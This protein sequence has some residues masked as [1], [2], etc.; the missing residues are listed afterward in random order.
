MAAPAIGQDTL[1]WLESGTDLELRRVSAGVWHPVGGQIHATDPVTRFQ[2][3]PEVPTLSVPDAPAQVVGLRTDLA[4]GSAVMDNLMAFLALIWSD[5]PVTCGEHLWT[6][7]VDTGLASFMTP[8]NVVDLYDYEDFY[9]ELYISVTP[10]ALQRQIDEAGPGPIVTDIPRRD[11]L[12]PISR[13]G[14]GDGAY[15]VVGLYDAEGA[16]VAIY[17]QFTG[18]EDEDW[19]FP[20]P[21]VDPGVEVQGDTPL[22]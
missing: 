5:A 3:G 8:Q 18:A 15:P 2:A 4:L 17:V 22:R 20:Q 6:M 21:C 1:D 19:L 12:F 16:M 13:A 9:G 7:A 10:S 11:L 14:W